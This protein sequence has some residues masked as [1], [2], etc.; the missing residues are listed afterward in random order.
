MRN[1]IKDS[2]DDLVFYVQ[3]AEVFWNAPQFPYAILRITKIQF[4]PHLVWC[5][6]ECG[7]TISFPECQF[8]HFCPCFVRM[9][10]CRK[11]C[12]PTNSQHV[13]CSELVVMQFSRL[14]IYIT[15]LNVRL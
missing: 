4:I 13:L 12:L 7:H 14:Y 2:L 8:N 1:V 10:S 11:T 15:F 3:L 5:F 9:T 6:N